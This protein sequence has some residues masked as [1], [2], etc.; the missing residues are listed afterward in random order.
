MGAAG[1]RGRGTVQGAAVQDG[2]PGCARG[3]T[4]GQLEWPREGR[5]YDRAD[6]IEF[7]VR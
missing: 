3:D 6:C 7:P 4:E 1:A 2:M 5:R